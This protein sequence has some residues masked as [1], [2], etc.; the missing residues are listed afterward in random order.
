MRVLTRVTDR[1]GRFLNLCVLLFTTC[2]ISGTFTSLASADQPLAPGELVTASYFYLP[3]NIFGGARIHRAMPGSPAD[4][5]VEIGDYSP[6][7]LAIADANTLYLLAARATDGPYHDR[8]WSI[9][10]A[11]GQLT[12]IGE[13]FNFRE[14][15]TIAIDSAG[16]LL[17]AF[18]HGEIHRVD[19]STGALTLLVD[20]LDLSALKK[21]AI[22]STGEIYAMVCRMTTTDIVEVQVTAD[23]EA[24]VLTPIFT[25]ED[26]LECGGMAMDPAG[27]LLV[28]ASPVIPTE[29][30]VAGTYPE[31]L[32]EQ[33]LTYHQFIDGDY[34]M[35]HY[36]RVAYADP[37]SGL[38]TN[39]VWHGM[40]AGAGTGFDDV[41]IDGPSVNCLALDGTGAPLASDFGVVYRFAPGPGPVGEID[42]GDWIQD[43]SVMYDPTQPS[44]VAVPVPPP[45]C[46]SRIAPPGNHGTATVLLSM[47][48]ALFWRRRR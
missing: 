36:P 29:L 41:T 37:S 48:A 27:N 12:L 5:V 23:P 18:P 43:I 47:L 15:R 10:V 8:L 38:M 7:S 39:L 32:Y 13:Y 4:V 6:R 46:S 24:P 28:F 22:A 40:L 25:E 45:G 3:G 34:V 30:Y 16:D 33:M 2:V 21:I 17:M 20:T 19:M 42:I 35:S 26:G 14:N 1:Q 11:T 9:D 44:P 31:S